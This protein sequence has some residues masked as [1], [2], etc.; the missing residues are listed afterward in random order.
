MIEASSHNNHI[1]FNQIN[2][3]L[4]SFDIKENIPSLPKLDFGFL[5]F[6]NSLKWQSFVSGPNIKLSY[7][8]SNNIVITAAI[9]EVDPF[10]N[11]PLYFDDNRMGIGREPMHNYLI[12]IAIP[13]NKSVT[14]LHIGDGTNG[15]SF[16]NA[17]S[18]G[19]LPQ[20]I[21]V[22]SDDTD[23][24]LYFLGKV[25]NDT[26]SNTPAIIF[27]GRNDDNSKLNNR[28]ILGISNASY[29]SFDVIVDHKGRI[30]VGK[31]PSKYKFEVEDSILVHDVYIDSDSSVISVVDELNLLREKIANLE[32]LINL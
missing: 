10:E 27:D 7:D 15:F 13:I 21:G 31:N 1:I 25:S 17:T 32:K 30:G 16:G 20:I 11:T 26:S 9:P 18:D 5:T 23:A 28:P 3:N 14:A 8:S 24:G 12:D 29:T 2:S 22:G 19:F 6:N 4:D